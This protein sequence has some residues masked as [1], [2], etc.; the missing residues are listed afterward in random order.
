MQIEPIST[1]SRKKYKSVRH[2]RPVATYGAKW[3]ALNKDTAKRMVSFERKVLRRMFGGIKVHENRRK[4]RINAVVLRFSYTFI[5]QN[6]LVEMLIEQ[7][8]RE[9]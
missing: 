7:I 4:R 1:Q 9:E 2:Y 8:V 6:E 5:S 3:W